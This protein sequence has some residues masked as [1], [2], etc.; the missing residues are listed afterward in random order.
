MTH[1]LCEIWLCSLTGSPVDDFEFSTEQLL[2]V[3]MKFLNSIFCFCFDFTYVVRAFLP[4]VLLLGFVTN[5]LV[6]V[7]PHFCLFIGKGYVNCTLLLFVL[8]WGV[9]F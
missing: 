3:S 7:F 6:V 1:R 4:M 8:F 9:L 5:C 2:P